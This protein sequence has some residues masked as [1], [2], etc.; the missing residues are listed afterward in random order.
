MHRVLFS[1]IVID[2]ALIAFTSFLGITLG[3][4]EGMMRHLYDDLTIKQRIKQII[5]KEDQ[6]KPLSDQK[7]CRMLEDEGMEIARRTVAKYREMLGINP[8]SK[9]KRLF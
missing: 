2:C 9:R 1:L 7:I 8:S 5:S 4:S 6:M 3:A